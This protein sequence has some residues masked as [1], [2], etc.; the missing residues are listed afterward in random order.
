MGHRDE[1]CDSVDCLCV[2]SFTDP[3]QENTKKFE[4]L[5]LVKHLRFMVL[6]SKSL[7]A[8]LENKLKLFPVSS[9]FEEIINILHHNSRHVPL[10]CNNAASCKLFL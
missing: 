5:L 2:F 8:A 3:P 4:I 10:Q 9:L 1:K 7:T 6:Y